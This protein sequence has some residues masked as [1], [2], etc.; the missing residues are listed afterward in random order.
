MDLN[1]ANCKKVHSGTEDRTLSPD[2]GNKFMFNFPKKESLSYVELKRI[3]TLFNV[4]LC[5]S[6]NTYIH[7]YIY[8]NRHIVSCV[9]IVY[10]VLHIHNN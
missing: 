6:Y 2:S 1:N 4:I 3:V 5:D 10:E 9:C 8:D 7:T